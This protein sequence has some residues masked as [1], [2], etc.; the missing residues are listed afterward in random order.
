MEFENYAKRLNSIKDI[1]TF[2][3]L[4][5][6]KQGH[7]RLSVKNNKMVLEEIQKLKFAQI[8]NKRYYFSNGIV[9]L[10]FLHSF[11]KDIVKFKEEK[12]KKGS[13]NIYLRKNKTFCWW[14]KP[15]QKI[16]DFLC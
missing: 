9:S 7:F 3:Q 1:K 16:T 5:H 14:K 15:C 4:L 10:H 11:V 12:K 6:K 8:N 2:G 13:K